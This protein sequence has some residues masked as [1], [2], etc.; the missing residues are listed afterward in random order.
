VQAH[1][2]D[3]IGNLYLQLNDL[4]RARPLLEEALAIRLRLHGEND[5]DYVATLEGLAEVA[6]RKQDIPGEVSLRTRALALRRTLSAPGDPR[7]LDAVSGLSFALHRAGDD[8]AAM[9]LFDEWTAAV[10]RQPDVLS[11]ERAAQLSLAADLLRTRGEL[12][13]AESLHRQALDIRRRF[14]GERHVMVAAGLLSLSSLLGVHQ[15]EE[16]RVTTVEA[17]DMLR[18]TYPDGHPQ[19][20]RALADLGLIDLKLK[21]YRDAQAPLRE[22]L[23]LRR[24]LQGD[25]TIVVARTLQDLSW[26]ISMDGDAVE[27]EALAR[28]SLGIY[29]A[30]FGPDNGLVVFA[31]VFLAEALRAQGRYDEAEPLMLSAYRRFEKPTRTGMTANWR[32]LTLGSLVRLYEARGDQ[33]EAAKYRALQD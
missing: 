24:R 1:L 19:L 8:S 29:R 31:G 16:A 6:D 14:Y 17:I 7:T 5:L 9:P 28:E 25:E 3:V 12:E 21:R 2:L 30:A 33:G 22:A 23:A 26:A 11:A 10:A 13:R 4:D 20:A 18:A 27:A 15:P 32:R